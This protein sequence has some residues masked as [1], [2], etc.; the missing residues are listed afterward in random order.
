MTEWKPF[1]VLPELDHP[2]HITYGSDAEPNPPV[3]RTH[4]RE[5]P[6]GRVYLQRQDGSEWKDVTLANAF[7]II[8]YCKWR[9]A[10]DTSATT[11]AESPSPNTP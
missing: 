9:Y 6:Y 2:F 4:I 3:L 1:C 10:T 8:R 7:W 5:L 11:A